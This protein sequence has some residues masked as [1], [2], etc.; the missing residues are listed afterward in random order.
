[1]LITPDNLLFFQL[2]GDG[3]QH[4]LFHH[5][6]RD[7]GVPRWPRG[8]TASCIRNSVASRS[9]EGIIPLYSALVRPR[10]EHCVQFWA[11][12]YKKRH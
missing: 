7:R 1:M 2:S 12:H 5:L 4:K 11:A 8:P 9:R 10:I 3:I 6:S